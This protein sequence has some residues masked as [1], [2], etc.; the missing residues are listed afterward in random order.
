M[1]I[2]IDIVLTFEYVV[3]I[4]VQ[5]LLLQIR[6]LLTGCQLLGQAALTTEVEHHNLF[7]NLKVEKF[8]EMSRSRTHIQD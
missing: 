3:T 8:G 7:C 4:S 2:E 5:G 1:M 6:N